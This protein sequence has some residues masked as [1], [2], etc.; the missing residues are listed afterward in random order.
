MK[1]LHIDTSIQGEGS[2]SRGISAEAVKRLLA[3]HPQAD[4]T[5]RD[6]AAT[7]LPHLTLGEFASGE[8][9]ASLAEFQAADIIVIGAGMYNFSVPSQLKAWID[10]IVIVNQTFRYTEAGPEGLVAGKRVI[11]ALAR[12]GYY[13]EGS[14][15]AFLEHAETYLRGVFGFLGVT[16]V[17]VIAA[18][19]ISIPNARDAAIETAERR[20]AALA[21]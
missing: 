13:G 8:S 7:P 2:A 21:I 9:K 19:G 14:P 11:I 3:R 4:V 17:E 15:A 16:N 20:A 6:F 5:Y 10:R 1:I 12:G 18:D